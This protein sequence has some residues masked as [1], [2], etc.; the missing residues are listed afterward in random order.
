[1]NICVNL[2]STSSNITVNARTIY[3]IICINAIYEM[4]TGKSANNEGN[5]RSDI[6]KLFI[7]ADPAFRKL[8]KLPIRHFKK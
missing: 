2:S 8:G 5:H 1:M 7:S 4:T 3:A 6:W